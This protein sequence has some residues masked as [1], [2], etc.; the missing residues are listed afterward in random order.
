MATD[1]QSMLYHAPAMLN[2]PELPWEVTVQ[3]DSIVAHWKWMDATFFA[4]HEIS[5]EVKSYTFTV[6]LS[7]KGTW[8]EFDMSEEKEKKF[9]FSGGNLSFGTSKDTFK[10]KQNKKSIEF[11]LGR[12][13]DTDQVGL[14][15]FKFDTSQ[16][17]GYIR[18]W[19]EANGWKKAGLFG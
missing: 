5:D 9:G 19:L 10:G 2:N 3:G 16:V 17:K 15:G 1:K 8:K 13:K 14:I 7:D 11:G 18:A 6:T 12:N 4:P